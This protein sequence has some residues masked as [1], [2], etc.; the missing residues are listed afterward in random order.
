MEMIQNAYQGFAKQ[1]YTMLDNLKLGY[2]G[3]KE[4]MERLLRDADKLSDAFSL[5]EDKN[6]ELVYSFADI[7][8]AI[9]IVQDDMSITGATAAEASTTIEGS[10]KSMKSAWQN[11]ITALGGDND[12]LEKA[13]EKFVATI[14]GD[15]NGN[16]GVLGN[17][18]PKVDTILGGILKLADA[19]LPK[20]VSA[21]PGL[22]EKYVPLLVN[23]AIDLI[24]IIIDGIV[25]NGD[26]LSDSIVAAISSII[27]HAAENTP[28]FIGSIISLILSLISELGENLDKILP[29][30]IVSITQT[31]T[32]IAKRAPEFTDAIFA[33][34]DGLVGVLTSPEGILKMTEAGVELLFSII[35][36][37]IGAV[38]KA[39]EGLISTISGV[40]TEW[41]ETEWAELGGNFISNLL[42]GISNGWGE[43]EKF[44]VEAWNGIAGMFGLGTIE[45]EDDS[46]PVVTNQNA[47]PYNELNDLYNRGVI[48]YVP[49]KPYK[50]TQNAPGISI[51]QNIY[52]EAKTAAD[53][54]EEA[55]YYQEKGVY[56]SGK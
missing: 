6:G 27:M 43:V 51:T 10:V 35:Y 5:Q 46:D 12:E 19:L 22:I 7:V 54:M 55:V 4:E 52:S 47:N 48:S 38:P 26:K 14:V 21:I 31:I 30:I 3:T 50:P 28:K 17:L 56:M 2:G 40:F 45:V 23:T 8:D 32:E 11:L 18:M 36:G 16:G 9:H 44:F 49:G 13:I 42:E 41:G 24:E 20:V 34:V 25:E 33:V 15:E 29:A 53:L 39:V 1:N 37:A